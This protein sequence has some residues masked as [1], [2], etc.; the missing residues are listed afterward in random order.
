MKIYNIENDTPCFVVPNVAAP[1]AEFKP[2]W[3][4]KDLTFSDVAFDAIRNHNQGA[5]AFH[6]NCLNNGWNTKLLNKA[7]TFVKG[8]DMAL[9]TDTNKNGEV[10]LL[11]VEQKFVECLC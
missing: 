3:T 5:T 7:I 8:R 9:F 4:R 10:S 6:E 11:V 1:A 2:F